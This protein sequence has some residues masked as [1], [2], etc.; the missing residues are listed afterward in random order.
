MI[1]GMRY[2]CRETAHAHIIDLCKQPRAK[3]YRAGEGKAVQL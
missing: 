1:S 3:P 2:T